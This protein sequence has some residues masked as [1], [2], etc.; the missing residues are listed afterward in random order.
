MS[1]SVKKTTTTYHE[2]GVGQSPREEVSYQLGADIDGVFV[3][4]TTLSENHVQNLIAAAQAT[5][6]AEKTAKG[7]EK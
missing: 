5:A 3:P 1:V 4:F 6:D 7:T 2:T